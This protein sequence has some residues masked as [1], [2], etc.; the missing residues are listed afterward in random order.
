MFE[1]EASGDFETVPMKFTL[2]LFIRTQSNPVNPCNLIRVHPSEGQ[3]IFHST[4][5]ESDRPE[6]MSRLISLF[7]GRTC[8]SVHT[9]VSRLT[10]L[11]T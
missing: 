9:T 4:D 11:G 1:I 2:Y 7:V 3:E 6:R 10:N 8:H 5:E